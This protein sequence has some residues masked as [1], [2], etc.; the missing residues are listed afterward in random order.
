MRT[1]LFLVGVVICAGLLLAAV[2][3]RRLLKVGDGAPEFAAGDAIFLRQYRGTKNIVLYFY[4]KDFTAGCTEEACA[5]RNNYSGK[6][7]S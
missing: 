2:E 4:P 6:I 7:I 1:A 3:E 5:F